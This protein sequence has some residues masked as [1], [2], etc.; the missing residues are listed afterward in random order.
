[1]L[2]ERK[3]LTEFIIGEQRRSPGATGMLTALLNG[4]RLSCKRIS[5]L[6]GEGS[7]HGDATAAAAVS[8]GR[9]LDGVARETFLRTL[10]WGGSVRG[11][12]C[13]GMREP[14]AVPV[15][16]PPHVSGPYLVVFDPLEGFTDLDVNV[17]AGSIFSIL[18]A[19]ARA[20][21]A[22]DGG[23]GLTAA[24][25]LQPGTRQVAAG[26]A[27]YGPATMIVFTVGN[28]VNGF[29]LNRGFGEF[30]L[31]H[32][33]LRI[34]PA[35][36]EVSVNTAS[37]RYWEP[38]VQRYV[39]ECLKGAEGPRAVDF[40][41]RWGASLVAEVHR[42]LLRGGVLLVP[43]ELREGSQ[44]GRLRLLSEANP[45]AMLVEQAGGAASTGRRSLLDVEPTTLEDLSPV[46]L[47]AREE[48][49]RLAQ[50][51]AEHD[52]GLE[53]AFSS[54]LFNE[55]SLFPPSR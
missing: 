21:D 52:Q 10:E 23:Q 45:M 16:P 1:M 17:P 34:A 25:F 11:M 27:V 22:T 44:Q 29:T 50:Y 18:R 15:P 32:P 47:G 19:P 14:Y 43:A 24:D 55:R 46:V 26:Y 51:H 35:T 38:P 40:S 31:T 7:L 41:T 54:P 2:T 39:D 13:E 49:E 33:G 36:R 9:A 42:I 5:W 4:I 20:G 48:V 28:G 8:A 53:P 12:V 37:A 30:H 6:V 3:T